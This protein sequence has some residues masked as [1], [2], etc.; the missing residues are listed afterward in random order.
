M[1]KKLT[2]DSKRLKKKKKMS[3]FSIIFPVEGTSFGRF[4]ALILKKNKLSNNAHEFAISE[5]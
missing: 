5:L 2:A 1:K 4:L 3:K